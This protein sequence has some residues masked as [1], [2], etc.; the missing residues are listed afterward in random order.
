MH[1][2]MYKRFNIHMYLVCLYDMLLNNIA[3]Y[4]RNRRPIWYHKW[5]LMRPFQTLICSPYVSSVQKLWLSIIGY[6]SIWNG[7]RTG[8]QIKR[9]LRSNFAKYVRNRRLKYNFHFKVLKWNLYFDI[10]LDA[11]R[12]VWR[13]ILNQLASLVGLRPLVD[14]GQSLWPFF[15]ILCI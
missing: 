7:L 10:K 8:R 2:N 14:E 4:V 12:G 15:H 13:L 6:I 1:L 11:Y 5:I 9:L 3:K